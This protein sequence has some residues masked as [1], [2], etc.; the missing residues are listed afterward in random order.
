MLRRK[1]A[2]PANPAGTLLQRVTSIAQVHL[3]CEQDPEARPEAETL[4]RHE[5]VAGPHVSAASALLPLIQRSRSLV[6]TM[7]EESDG[8]V[9]LPTGVG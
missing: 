3:A 1:E 7:Y 6:A 5:F 9:R 8:P 4:Q 2:L